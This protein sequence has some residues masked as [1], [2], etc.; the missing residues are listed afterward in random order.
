MA[1]LSAP[2]LVFVPGYGNSEP[3]HWQGLWHATSPSSYWV[4][5]RDWENPERDE[6]VAAL[7]RTLKNVD[8]PALLI[9]HSLGCSTIVEWS[10]TSSRAVAGALLVAPPDPL[11][12]AFPTAIRGFSA[13]TLRP[14][15]FPTWIAASS[16]DPYAS[17]ARTH[18]LAQAWGARVVEFGACGHINLES[19]FGPWPAGEKLLADFLGSLSA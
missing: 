13:P 6:W 4:K 19:G 11:A 3:T 16:D 10:H 14:L 2:P 18:A 12:S 5:Q 1:S 17:L 7:E 8:R 15:R 9:G